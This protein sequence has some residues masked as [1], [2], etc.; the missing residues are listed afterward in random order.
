M[1]VQP[2]RVGTRLGEC[3]ESE[4]GSEGRKVLSHVAVSGQSL[5]TEGTTRA[6][7]LRQQHQKVQG[8]EARQRGKWASQRDS[9]AGSQGACRTWRGLKRGPSPGLQAAIREQSRDAEG[10]ST[11]V[12]EGGDSGWERVVT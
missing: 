8:G 12:Q 9:G 7:V 6:K 5:E 11:T 10:S 2:F 1:H 4:E 3:E